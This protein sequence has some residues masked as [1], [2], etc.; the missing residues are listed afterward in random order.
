[1]SRLL[2]KVLLLLLF[3]GIGA[4]QQPVVTGKVL[5]SITN[6]AGYPPEVE[7][8]DR[9]QV[10]LDKQPAKILSLE[11]ASD[12]PVHIAVIIDR[13][14]P[15]S[16]LR[17]QEQQAATAF[18]NRFV[19]P[20]VDRPFMLDVATGAPNLTS[21]RDYAEFRAAVSRRRNVSGDSVLEGLQSYVQTL[22]KMYGENF[23]G[24]RAVIL[25][26]NGGTQI[27]QDFLPKLREYVIINKITVFV[28]NTDWTW[29]YFGMNSSGL[30]QE[31]AEDTG[32]TYEDPTTSTTRTVNLQ[33]L[34]DILN[35]VGALI[36][37]QQEITFENAKPDGKLH[38]LNVQSMDATLVLHAPHYYIRK[39]STTR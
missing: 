22:G 19:R 4:A 7:L 18:L 16:Q 20:G 9:L 23:P 31:F 26:A 3:T 34:P 5:V 32:G 8:R 13:S 17:N 30:M 38:S 25:F 24:R 27:G 36:R 11:S 37:N 35:H 12:L 10:A 2:G 28:I 14:G 33:Q 39:D 21:V 6:K 29:R 1:M 15:P